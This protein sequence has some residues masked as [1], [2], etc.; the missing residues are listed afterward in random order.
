MMDDRKRYWPRTIDDPAT[1]LINEEPVF[2]NRDGATVLHRWP[3][4]P[5][6]AVLADALATTEALLTRLESGVKMPDDVRLHYET[7][8]R[9]LYLQTQ[10]QVRV[11]RDALELVELE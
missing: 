9:E 1:T 5:L 8:I 7:A 3:S 6:R 11:L 10:D 2:R 4:I